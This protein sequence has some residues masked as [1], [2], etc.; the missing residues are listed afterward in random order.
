MGRV[1]VAWSVSLRITL[2]LTRSAAPS[3]PFTS[4]G[5]GTPDMPLHMRQGSLM[6]TLVQQWRAAP[7]R[8]ALLP[9]YEPVPRLGHE[10]ERHSAAAG[11]TQEPETCQSEL[12]HHASTPLPTG[13]AA[14][15]HRL[16]IRKIVARVSHGHVHQTL[17]PS[18]IADAVKMRWQW[19]GWPGRESSKRMDMGTAAR[20]Q[21]SV[22]HMRS[23]T[24][25][26][27][28]TMACMC[29]QKSALSDKG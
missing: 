14:M 9:R 15:L 7:Q 26:N 21:G 10:R 13:Q 17:G 18:G 3:R 6:A 5:S 24:H 29:G 1:G 19:L 22:R 27:P 2:V 16:H 4:S 12:G 23:H 25:S 28:I 11:S 8:V 20:A